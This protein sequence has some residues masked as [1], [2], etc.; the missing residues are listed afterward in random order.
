MKE[1]TVWFTE[2]RQE[3]T[4]P[5]ALRAIAA[6]PVRA[7]ELQGNV[8]ICTVTCPRAATP[9]RPVTYITA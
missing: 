8:I 6:G 5:G 4:A 7:P 2:T 9:L 3:P 1:G